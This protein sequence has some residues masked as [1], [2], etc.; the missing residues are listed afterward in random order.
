MGARGPKPLPANV[1]ALRGNSAYLQQRESN[2]AI[3]P[4]IEIPGCPRH[5]L[6]E[7]RKEWKRISPELE[8]LGIISRIDRTALAMYCQEYAWWVWHE[9]ALQRAIKLSAEKAAAFVADPANEG[10]EWTGGDGFMLPT[11]NGNWAYSPH[12]VARNKHSA[13]L[14]RFLANFG[15]SPSARGRVQASAQQLTLPFGAGNGATSPPPAG[16]FGA[17]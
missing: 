5:L 3:N 14:D 6:A 10:K 17:L 7:A 9:E 11:V 1:L 4:E 16:G 2:G 13:Q 8:Q 15:M 12:W